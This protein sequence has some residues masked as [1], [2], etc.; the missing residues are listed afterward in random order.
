MKI[1]Q[2][3]SKADERLQSAHPSWQ[4]VFAIAGQLTCLSLSHMQ[5][6]ILQIIIS[7]HLSFVSTEYTYTSV[8]NIHMF[9]LDLYLINIY[10]CNT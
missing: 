4:G 10:T 3:F 7:Q 1:Q 8:L 6:L 5:R 2:A 9:I